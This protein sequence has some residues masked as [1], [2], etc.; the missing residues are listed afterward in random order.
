MDTTQRTSA[1]QTER[2]V[3]IEKAQE[4]IAQGHN[5]Y[6]ASVRRDMTLAELKKRFDELQGQTVTLSGRIKALRL[7]GKIGF[8]TMEDESL[9]EGFQFIFK[10]DE[11]ASSSLTFEDFKNLF[12]KGDYIQATGYLDH[13]KRGEAS[14]FVTEYTILTKALRSLPEKLDDIEQKYRKRYVDMKLHPEVRELFTMKSR[15]WRATREF[16]LDNGF[17]EVQAPTMEHTTGGAEA[18]PF[19]THHNALG[20]DFYLRISSELFLKRYIVGGFEKVFDIDKN[21]RNEGIDDE[22]LQEYIQMEFYWAYSDFEDLLQYTEKLIKYVIKETFGTTSLMYSEDSMVNW[23]VE[24]PRMSYYDFV[25]HFAGIKLQEYDTVEKLRSLA[26]ELGLTYQSSDGYGR[27]VDLIYKKTARP[28]CIEPVWLIDVPVELSPLAK[29]DPENPTQTLRAQLI[30]YGSELTN[31]FAELNDPVDQLN[32]FKEQKQLRDAGDGEAMMLDTDFVEALEYGMPPTCGFGFS[33]RVFSVLMKKPIRETTAF[34][35]VKR[36]HNDEDFRK[37]SNK[38]LMVAHS[39]LFRDKENPAWIELNVAAHLAASFACRQGD[40]LEIGVST[41]QDGVSI[42]M[43]IQH[44][45][46]MM[47]ETD[48]VKM[49]EFYTQVSHRSDIYYSVFTRDMLASSNDRKVDKS[50]QS[51]QIEDIDIL[52]VLVFGEKKKIEQLTSDFDL[53]E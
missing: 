5:P 27:L 30:A 13:S 24:W 17:L 25:E 31:G 52:G 8:T 6:S 53:Y 37:Q 16:M 4:L 21:Y 34:P 41:S 7:S 15:F 43:N 2:S 35:M 12:D 26:E 18:E 45:I 42:P 39:I 19:I 29:R 48:Q 11:L 20:E 47:Q 46:I 33:E 36:K 49:T 38:Q 14:L 32:R 22:H 1:I 44:A 3:R 51:K 10:Q 9:P 28:K 50:H 23:D 40:L